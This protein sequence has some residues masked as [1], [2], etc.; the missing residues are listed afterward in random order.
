MG[1]MATLETTVPMA[2]ATPII[3]ILIP[4]IDVATITIPMATGMGVMRGMRDTK[5]GAGVLKAAVGT[6]VGPAAAWAA[7]TVVGTGDIIDLVLGFQWVT[8]S[9]SSTRVHLANEAPDSRS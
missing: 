1:A 2:I 3:T 6:A 8:T 4:I 7:A 5:E 9:A